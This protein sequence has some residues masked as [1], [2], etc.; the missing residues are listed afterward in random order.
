M[1][2]EEFV[3]LA[4]RWKRYFCKIFFGRKNLERDIFTIGCI[5]FVSWLIIAS[6]IPKKSEYIVPQIFVEEQPQIE[7]LALPSEDEKIAEIQK[8]EDFD[9]WKT[10]QNQWYGFEIKYPEDYEAPVTKS[11]VRGSKWTQ[12][13]QFRKSEGDG[14]NSYIGFD[15]VIYDLKK[16]KNVEDTDEFI[17][18]TGENFANESDCRQISGHLLENEDFPAE[19]IYIPPGDSCYLSDL[20]YNLVRDEYI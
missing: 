12:R 17:K 11:V 3:K 4:K 19:R 14:S 18:K 20:F 2:R 1:K 8:N 10:Y 15:V 13:Y 7:T 5:I 16:I 6:N 9:S